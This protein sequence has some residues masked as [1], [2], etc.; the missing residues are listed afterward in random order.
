MNG[1]KIIDRI[2]IIMMIELFIFSNV[3]IILLCL[4]EFG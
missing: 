4:V 3:A 1:E 2:V